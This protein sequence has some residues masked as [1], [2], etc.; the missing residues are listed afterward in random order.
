M[1]IVL[2]SIENPDRT[3]VE[4]NNDR[5]CRFNKLIAK[6]R[7]MLEGYE[8]RTYTETFHVEPPSTRVQFR[9]PEDIPS[10]TE[11][12]PLPPPGSTRGGW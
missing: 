3:G 8:G 11:G 1:G 5:G 6:V 9:V 4:F 10:L 12:G 7:L 2:E